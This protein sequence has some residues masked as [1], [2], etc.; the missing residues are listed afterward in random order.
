MSRKGLHGDCGTWGSTSSQHLQAGMGDA[1]RKP[2]KAT[3]EQPDSTHSPASKSASWLCQHILGSCPSWAHARALLSARDSGCEAQAQ[4]GN[5][6]F[7]FF[8]DMILVLN[9]QA[10][11]SYRQTQILTRNQHR[12]ARTIRMNPTKLDRSCGRFDCACCCRGAS[13]VN[14]R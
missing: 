2:G 14:T 8:T 11:V 7:L 4:L 1:Q 12:A 13:M 3:R 5:T 6:C 9:Q 10:S